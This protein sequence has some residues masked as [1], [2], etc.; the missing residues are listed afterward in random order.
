MK[1]ILIILVSSS[2]G[3]SSR[4][5]TCAE[6]EKIDVRVGGA[7][8]LEGIC[9]FTLNRGLLPLTIPLKVISTAGESL[10][11]VV[12]QM[13]DE[14]DA[15][16]GHVEIQGARRAVLLPIGSND[17]MEIDEPMEF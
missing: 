8:R 7:Y 10:N 2:E 5:L 15:E 1:I 17:Q 14:I 11:H 12:P 16:A 4:E 3:E 6:M 9:S 13:D